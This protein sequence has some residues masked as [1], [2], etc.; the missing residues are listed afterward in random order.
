MTLI[1]MY[2]LAET[3]LESLNCGVEWKKQL[4]KKN[5]AKYLTFGLWKK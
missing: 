1:V 5:N 4:L 3:R 2:R